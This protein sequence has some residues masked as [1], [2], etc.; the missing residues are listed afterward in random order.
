MSWIADFFV[1]EH[2]KTEVNGAESMLGPRVSGASELGEIAEALRGCAITET[3]EYAPFVRAAGTGSALHEA[4]VD[5]LMA[6]RTGDALMADVAFDTLKATHGAIAEA[7]RRGSFLF[8]ERV[9][10]EAAWGDISAM[11]S[12]A[13]EDMGLAAG[14]QLGA[15]DR[16]L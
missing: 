1:G 6:F 15:G 3:M 7:E 9:A 13:S 11:M 8:R 14:H 4:R 12:V 10:R 16:S 5:L 2:P